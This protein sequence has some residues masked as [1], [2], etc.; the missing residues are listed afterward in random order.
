MSNKNWDE[1]LGVLRQRHEEVKEELFN[2]E[3]KIEL[4]EQLQV[5]ALDAPVAK[6]RKVE[7]ILEQTHTKIQDERPVKLR[8]KNEESSSDNPPKRRGRPPKNPDAV[9]NENKTVPLGT[10]VLSIAK[11]LNRPFSL[12]E[13]VTMVC[14]SD[15]QSSGDLSNMVYQ[16]LYKLQ[17]Q[18]KI[19]NNGDR[20]YSFDSSID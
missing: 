18:N 7:R 14:D 12:S 11:T 15:Y 6:S 17:K 1:R 9:K 16:S 5:Q 20:T 2:I 4:I 8:K 3:E 13:M 19:I 10:L